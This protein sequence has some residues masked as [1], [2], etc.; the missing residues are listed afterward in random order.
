MESSAKNKPVRFTLNLRY[1]NTIFKV[2]N[3]QSASFLFDKDARTLTIKKYSFQLDIT[4][5]TP[6]S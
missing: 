4:S 2:L 3:Y 6:N 5:K 1:I